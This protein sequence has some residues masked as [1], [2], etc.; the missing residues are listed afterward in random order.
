MK[1]AIA[2]VSLLGFLSLEG[3][4]GSPPTL[5]VAQA[6]AN[7][8]VPGGTLALPTAPTS[9]VFAAGSDGQ[10]RA[11]TPRLSP[12][13]DPAVVRRALLRKMDAEIDAIATRSR[14]EARRMLDAV[15]P[16]PYLGVDSDPGQGGLVLNAIYADTGAERAGLA[17]GD[18][19]RS[20]GG[21]V[22]DTKAALARAVRSH[23]V[24]EEVDVTFVRDGE[25][26]T[27]SAT[28][29][30][31]PEEDEDEDE[32]FPELAPPTGPLPAPSVLSFD[33]EPIGKL[34]AQLVSELGGHG[35]PGGWI[36][37]ASEPGRT[38][39]Q[40]DADTTGIR[41]PMAIVRGFDAADATIRVRFRYLGGRV[42]R[43][44]GVV[45]RWRDP[46]N[47]LVARANAAEGD[48]RIF[49]VVNGDRRTL[50]GGIAKGATDDDAWHTLEFTVR[51]A[52]LEAVLDGKV[53]AKSYDTFFRHGKAGLWRKS[54]SRTEF[55]DLAL[56]AER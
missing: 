14:L 43:A 25:E 30:P 18:V 39:V 7:A 35:R 42:D 26:L 50:P 2:L 19:L 15:L 49:R 55:D 12:S 22:T 5:L 56:A 9:V 48:L 40:D 44:A 47:Y 45:L 21:V 36:V 24:G 46:G 11:R 23:R 52:E 13:D 20:F 37:R 6:S 8:N 1:T 29:G 53:R 3:R 38:L 16:I 17:K 28:L 4:G 27:V 54:D 10:D 41:F 51:G 32:Q 33:E 34:P 31:R